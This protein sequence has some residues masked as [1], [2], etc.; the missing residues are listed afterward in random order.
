MQ[1]LMLIAPFALASLFLGGCGP[2]KPKMVNF[3]G[4]VIHQGKGVTAGSI[5]FF[6]ESSNSYQ[7]DNPSSILQLDGSFTAKTFPFGDGIPPGT[8]KVTL[9]PAV[10]SRLNAPSYADPA[11]TPW[12][13]E[14]PDAGLKDKVLEVKATEAEPESP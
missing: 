6:P 12:T 5:H 4:K 2:E 7:K 1:R 13:V 14:V 8:Y 11:K 3:S 10:A 9:A